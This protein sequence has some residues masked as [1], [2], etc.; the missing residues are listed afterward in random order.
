MMIDIKKIREE[1]DA[2]A[3]QF[4]LRG[5]EK[6]NI[7]KVKDLKFVGTDPSEKRGNLKRNDKYWIN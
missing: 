1:F 3:G 6:A 5:V 2:P 4:A 7:Q